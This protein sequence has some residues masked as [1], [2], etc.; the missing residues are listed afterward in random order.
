V[1]EIAEQ[2]LPLRRREQ[3]R[4]SEQLRYFRT[5]SIPV[6]SAHAIIPRDVIRSF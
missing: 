2:A 5:S 4:E 1:I 6:A 3:K